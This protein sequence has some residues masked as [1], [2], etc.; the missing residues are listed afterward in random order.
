M[1]VS[2]M[3]VLPALLNIYLTRQRLE[4]AQAEERLQKEEHMRI[5][6]QRMLALKR[7][8]LVEAML[9]AQQA[10]QRLEK[11]PTPGYARY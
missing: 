6:Q 5:V 9:K 4:R 1:T 8:Q 7:R 10:N 2:L 3:A 11:F